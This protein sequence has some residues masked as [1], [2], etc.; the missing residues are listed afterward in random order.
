MGLPW[1]ER[2]N[3]LSIN[4]DAASRD[5]VA[6]LAA[7]LSAALQREA[8]IAER[9]T[10]EKIAEVMNKAWWDSPMLDDGGYIARA[11]LRLMRGEEGE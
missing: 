8:G 3:M 1:H 2:I 7:D 6:R 11:V 10:V 9:M 4:P 5:D